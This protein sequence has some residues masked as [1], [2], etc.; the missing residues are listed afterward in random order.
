MC[1]TISNVKCP[2][3]KNLMRL[4]DTTHSN[5]KTERANIGD[6]TGNIYKCDNCKNYWLENFLNNNHLEIWIY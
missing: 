4:N 3:C 2:E 6:H 1:D 5:I